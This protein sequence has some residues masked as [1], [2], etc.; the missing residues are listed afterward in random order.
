MS[1]DCGR[2]PELDAVRELL[3]PHLPAEDG[4]RRIDNAFEAQ[5]D[6]D[7]WRRVEKIARREQSA[8]TN[9]D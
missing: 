7:R 3:F 1:D 8:G 9:G 4:W 5:R 6:E 2:S